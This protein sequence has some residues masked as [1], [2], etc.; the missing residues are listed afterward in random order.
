[1]DQVGWCASFT[2][3]SRSTSCQ[4]AYRNRLSALY[5]SEMDG[6]ATCDVKG[7]SGS[8]SAV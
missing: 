1:V 5:R 6:Q 2:E 7:G 8:F 3:A 4:V